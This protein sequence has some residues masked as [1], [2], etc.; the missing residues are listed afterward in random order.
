MVLLEQAY[1]ASS[2]PNLGVKFVPCTKENWSNMN[3]IILVTWVE[4]VHQWFETQL[5]LHHPWSLVHES[6]LLDVQLK[7]QH[8]PG[9]QQVE[10][11]SNSGWRRIFSSMLKICR[12]RH[13]SFSKQIK[14]VMNHWPEIDLNIKLVLIMRVLYPTIEKLHS[15]QHGLKCSHN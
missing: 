5:F 3:Q 11:P 8:H 9:I 13:Y 12:K 1:L 15:S 4:W 10:P 2:G 6:W 7:T 14:K